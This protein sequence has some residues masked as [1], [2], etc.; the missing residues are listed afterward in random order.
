MILI[1]QKH[2]GMLD[3][4]ARVKSM[5]AHRTTWRA[6]LSSKST[7]DIGYVP[8]DDRGRSNSLIVDLYKCKYVVDWSYI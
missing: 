2:N 3:I 5:R 8:H 7:Y 6:S 1:L 4:R